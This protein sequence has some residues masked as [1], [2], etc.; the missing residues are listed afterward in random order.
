MKKCPISL[1]YWLV[2]KK[3]GA[4]L[5]STYLLQIGLIL[6][7]VGNDFLAKVAQ[8]FDNFWAT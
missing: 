8:I 7:D 5:G 1:W 3:S 2:P 6:T 4:Y